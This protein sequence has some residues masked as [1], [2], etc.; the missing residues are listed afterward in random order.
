[1]YDI[2][3]PMLQGELGTL[4][5]GVSLESDEKDIGQIAKIN[6]YIAAVILAGLGAGILVFLVIGFLFSSRII[7]L[8]EFASKIGHGDLEAKIDIKSEDEI[9]ALACAL[10]DMVSRLKQNVEEIERLNRIEER[11]KIAFDLH[12]GCAQHAANIIKRVELCERLYKTDPDKAFKELE[13]LKGCARDT[14][15]WTRQMI[16]DLKSAEDAEFNLLNKINDHI[17]A[18]EK[19]NDLKIELAVLGAIDNIQADKARSIFY[20]I[21]EA[22]ANAEKHSGAKKIGLSL[23][24]GNNGL[25]I[26]I[27][28]NGTGFDINERK[29]VARSQKRWGLITMRERTEALGGSLSIES[30][31][32]M[33]TEVII[34]IPLMQ[35]LLK[36]PL[37]ENAICRIA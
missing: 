33:G 24:S 19:R 34:N 4:H 5:L 2:A 7:R 16:Y 1:M 6:Y 20:I 3:F 35:Q 8:K 17:F 9:G 27:K 30:A 22:L 37:K 32:A 13:T 10:N 11:N 25:V 21:T 12:D 23:N 28:D 14:L 36:Q 15:D 29:A 26:N 31:Q 18:F